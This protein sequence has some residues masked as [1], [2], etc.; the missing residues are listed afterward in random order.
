[1]EFPSLL[2]KLKDA[3]IK[4]NENDLSGFGH[5]YIQTI[6]PPSNADLTSEWVLNDLR[7][8]HPDMFEAL[9]KSILPTQGNGSDEGEEDI[10]IMTGQS[11][12]Q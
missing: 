5:K 7:T 12:S 4:E 6:R 3:L 10:K 1:M 11:M 2:E 9:I 8:R